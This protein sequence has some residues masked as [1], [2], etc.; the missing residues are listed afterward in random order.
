M[1][2]IFTLAAFLLAGYVS[3]GQSGGKLTISNYNNY[4]ISVVV[5]GRD[6]SRSR[7]S[8]TFFINDLSSGYHNVKIYRRNRGTRYGSQSA[9]QLIYSSNILIRRGYHV[10]ITINRFGKAFKDEMQINSR[11]TSEGWD[12]NRWDRW[13][14]DD[15]DDRRNDRDRWD[16]RDRRDDRN[17]YDRAMNETDFSRLKQVLSNE[18]FDDTRK[19]MAKQAT[20]QNRFTSA[21]VKQLVELFSFD[22]SRLELAKYFYE[23]TTDKQNYII[24][25]D[26]LTFSNSKNEL[27]KFISEQR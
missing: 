9:Q 14:W 5:D 26:A 4:S 17:R 12:D 2:S 16:D 19:N 22:E 21:Q 10:D 18:S 20:V 27:S 23:F 3:S 24:V 13:E 7:G 15:R 6:F 11:Y 1:K 8:E 25:S